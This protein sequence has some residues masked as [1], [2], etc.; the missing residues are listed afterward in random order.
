MRFRHIS[1]LFFVSMTYIPMANAQQAANPLPA[2]SPS[3]PITL[4]PDQTSTAGEPLASFQAINASIDSVLMQYEQLTGK[5]LIKD[6]NL[7]ANVLPITISVPRPVPKSELVRII[8]ASLLLN[9]IVL[10]PAQEP[11]TVKVININTGKNPRSEGVRLFEGLES[12]PDGEQVVSYYMPFEYISASEALTVFQTHILPRAYTSFVP[13]NSAQAILITESTTVIRQL[14]ALKEL[15]DIPPVKVV[16]EFVPLVRADAERVAKTINE[17]LDFQRKARSG[18]GPTPGVPA[19]QNAPAPQAA[20]G[21]GSTADAGLL[22]SQVEVIADTRTNRILLVGHPDT[23][24]YFTTLIKQF[25]A[26]V[27]IAAPLEYHLRYVAAG[28][29]LPVLQDVLTEEPTEQ[30]Q[31]VSGNQQQQQPSQ[32]RSVNL[33]SSSSSNNNSNAYSPVTGTAGSVGAGEDLLQEPNE[34]LGPQA[35][36]VGRSRIISDAK[37]NKILVIGPPEAVRKVQTILDRLDRRPQQVYLST[38]I[39][40]LQLT[41]DFQFGVDFTQTFKKLSEHSGFASANLNSQG[42]V[43]SNGQVVAIPSSLNTATTLPGLS[44]LTIYGQLGD[45]VSY[46]VRALDSRSDFKILARPAVYTAN[47]KRAVISSGERVPVPQS[48]LSNLTTGT[49]GGIIN[50]SSST[51]VA[52]TV[53]YEDVELRLEVIPLINSNNEVTL[54]IAQ[55]NDTLGNNVNISGNQVPIVNSQRLTTTVTVPSGCTIVLGGLIKDQ[56]TKDANGIPYLMD[57]PYLGNLFKYTTND[58]ERDE[59]LVF[60]QPTVV[61]DD[62]QTL[63]AS[64][65][66]E[67]RTKV[68]ADTY[69]LAHPGEPAE[70]AA[71]TPSKKPRGYT[72]EY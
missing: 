41:K 18:G 38:V 44:G 47:N 17:L 8:E 6:S 48:T 66:E 49:T 56:I 31:G 36:I 19:V 68:G 23:I 46:F 45:A 67:Q 34:L 12:L 37:D 70:A 43:N 24:P 33:G 3:Q 59:L 20:P 50:N 29:V 61:N 27:A 65:K 2:A 16:S 25:D 10:V 26:A 1:I 63:R 62:V 22:S 51:A 53:G 5:V 54:K 14:I 55:I 15:I 35:V 60:I 11:N 28:E 42:I 30:G 71:P 9:N 7:G 69:K 57:I 4:S 52:A 21:A 40:Q 58:R 32:Q 64:L 39:G 13:I 72:K